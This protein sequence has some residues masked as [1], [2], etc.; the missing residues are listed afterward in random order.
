MPYKALKR[1]GFY[2]DP[3]RHDADRLIPS[4]TAAHQ[5]DINHGRV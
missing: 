4:W 2:T 3:I 5:R 1:M